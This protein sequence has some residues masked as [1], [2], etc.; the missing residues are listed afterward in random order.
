MPYFFLLIP[1]VHLISMLPSLNGLGIREVAYVYFLKNHIGTETAAAVGILWLSLLIFLSLI[2]G[3]IYLFRHDY[4][5][6][7]KKAVT[8]AEEVTS[9]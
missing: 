5:I 3:L 6:Q 2:G 8:K 4:H 1:V 7:F 9:R